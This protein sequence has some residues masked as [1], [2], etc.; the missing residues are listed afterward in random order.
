MQLRRVGIV[1][2][3]Q[4]KSERSR[5]FTL[6]ELLTVIFIIGLLAAILIPAISKVREKARIG[7]AEADLRSVATA[8]SAYQID[9]GSL[10]PRAGCPMAYFVNAQLDGQ[11]PSVDYELHELW[12]PYLERCELIGAD[13][14]GK[15]YDRWSRSEDL[16][17]NQKIEVPY[18][19][20]GE[21]MAEDRP[22]R[23]IVDAIAGFHLFRPPNGI[24]DR[25]QVPY[26]YFPVNSNNFGK[27]RQILSVMVQLN[28]DD[29]YANRPYTMAELTNPRGELDIDIDGLALPAQ[30]YDR[31][32]L[33]SLG[34]RESD[35]GIVPRNA[36]NPDDLRLRAFFRATR[37]LNN[38]QT[39]DFDFRARSKRLE[40]YPLPDGS[41]LEGVMIFSGP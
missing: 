3:N 18:G 22:V 19:S 29:V 41:V 9:N 1:H 27:F 23:F 35:Q 14:Q 2:I 6:I 40:T 33:F 13:V 36:D 38:N 26:Q 17:K 31:F 5:G 24:I 20:L 16:N 7:A 25:G 15:F 10:P 11:F 32:V 28:E 39:F 4:H 12:K 21:A 34:P 30:R 37:D 8:L